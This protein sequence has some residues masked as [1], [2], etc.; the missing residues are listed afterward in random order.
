MEDATL[1][2]PDYSEAA[3]AQHFFAVMA[4]LHNDE[5]RAKAHWELALLY[6]KLHIEQRGDRQ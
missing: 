3:N 6:Q 5:P 2:A 4:D 1:Q